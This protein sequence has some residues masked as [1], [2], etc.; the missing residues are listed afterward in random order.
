VIKR[1]ACESSIGMTVS[2]GDFASGRLSG[3]P[4]WSFHT[5]AWLAA[6]R[7]FW[8]GKIFSTK[9][10][11]WAALAGAIGLMESPVEAGWLVPASAVE[12]AAL[13]DLRDRDGLACPAEVGELGLERRVGSR[14]GRLRKPHRHG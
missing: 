3:R 11:S 6:G 10:P 7:S 9:S 8:S 5:F 12:A 14:M 13:D 2:N 1:S 4:A